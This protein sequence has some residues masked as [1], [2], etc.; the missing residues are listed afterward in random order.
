[1]EGVGNA[2]GEAPTRMAH[3]GT[4]CSTMRT[5]AESAVP[6]AEADAVRDE[7]RLLDDSDPVPPIHT[8]VVTLLRAAVKKAHTATRTFFSAS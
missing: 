3:V 8:Q 5:V 2:C 6:R 1:M 7:R 4:G